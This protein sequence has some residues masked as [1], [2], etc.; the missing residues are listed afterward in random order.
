MTNEEDPS[1]PLSLQPPRIAAPRRRHELIVQVL[2]GGTSS[3]SGTGIDN[4]DV[5]I[6][7]DS[8]IPMI[9]TNDTKKE[10]ADRTIVRLPLLIGENW[11]QWS[12]W[13][14]E[15][16]YPCEHD[17]TRTRMSQQSHPTPQ[18]HA[19]ALPTI[20]S[21]SEELSDMVHLPP[22][23]EEINNS[24]PNTSQNSTNGSDSTTGSTDDLSVLLLNHTNDTATAPVSAGNNNNHPPATL[25]ASTRQCCYLCF[26]VVLALPTNTNSDHVSNTTGNDNLIGVTIKDMRDPIVPD[27][28][29]QSHG[30]VHTNHSN[31]HHWT[32]HLHPAS[33]SSSV[34]HQQR[35]PTG[36]GDVNPTTLPVQRRQSYQLQHGDS[37]HFRQQNHVAMIV[38]YQDYAISESQQQQL[39]QRSVASR[40]TQ[41]RPATQLP[42]PTAKIWNTEQSSDPVDTQLTSQDDDFDETRIDAVNEFFS[43]NDDTNV[44]TQSATVFHSAVDMNLSTQQTTIANPSKDEPVLHL[45][46][47]HQS[48]HNDRTD[49]GKNI[50]DDDDD[51]DDV[52]TIDPRISLRKKT[53]ARNSN[54]RKT[55]RNVD[56]LKNVVNDI[57]DNSRSQ[58]P[59]LN[60]NNGD[61]KM[62]L[63]PAHITTGHDVV[64][65]ST[66]DNVPTSPA[67]KHK[68]SSLSFQNMYSPD[69]LAATPVQGFID[70]HSIPASTMTNKAVDKPLAVKLTR[71]SSMDSIADINDIQHDNSPNIYETALSSSRQP[72]SMNEGNN[73]FVHRGARPFAE[74]DSKDAVA[75]IVEL[76]VPSESKGFTKDTDVANDNMKDT[77]TTPAQ[78]TRH[79]RAIPSTPAAAIVN[80][81]STGRSKRLRLEPD[82]GKHNNNSGNCDVMNCP[83]TIRI[84]TTGFELDEKQKLVSFFCRLK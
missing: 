56:P 40:E 28:F 7:V 27:S 39:Q 26:D 5:G 23:H 79:K 1:L 59:L 63:P 33:S 43:Q 67:R 10:C 41:S 6:D 25:T 72:Y 34:V 71:Q 44:P 69:L 8:D 19:Q 82:L 75:T 2:K 52:S 35:L 60:V 42:P 74:S 58:L 76:V 61:S 77:S 84:L 32:I 4:G 36:T 15:Y 62:Q 30:I 13:E 16:Q 17:R 22:S 12:E 81:G 14:C 70:D 37:L 45:S 49:H 18:S 47:V 73:T 51:D 9:D 48:I 3:A 24:R 57:V 29:S 78:N 66:M 65:T 50:E 46:T 31:N 20:V 80:T 38:Q 55:T 68:E 64:F 54:I 21:L 53:S 11:L 83:D